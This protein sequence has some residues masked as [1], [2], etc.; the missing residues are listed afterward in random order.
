MN[1]QVNQDFKNLTKWLN[2]NNICLNITQTEAALFKLS[3][4]TYR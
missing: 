4:K 2:T 3:N 1:K